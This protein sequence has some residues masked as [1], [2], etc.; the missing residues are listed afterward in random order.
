MPIPSLLVAAD[1]IVIG[2]LPGTGYS[3]FIVTD[4]GVIEAFASN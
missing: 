3:A 2:L 4:M 1:M